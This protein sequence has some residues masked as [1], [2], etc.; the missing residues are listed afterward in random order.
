MNRFS[1]GGWHDGGSHGPRAEV[2]QDT[3]LRTEH[4]HELFK[5]RAPDVQ[6]LLTGP[7]QSRNLE[8][9]ASYYT[10]HLS[11]QLLVVNHDY[12]TLGRSESNLKVVSLPNRRLLCAHLKLPSAVQGLMQ[13]SGSP[14]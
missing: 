10:R 6:S 9:G 12:T 8:K 5:F 1:S 7:D 14:A 11:K 3:S 2:H 4:V 13:R